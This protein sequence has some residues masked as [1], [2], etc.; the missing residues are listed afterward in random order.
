MSF[1]IISAIGSIGSAMATIMAVLVS[2][3]VWKSQR[4]LSQR[5]LLIPLWSHMSSINEISP[6]NPVGP[7][8][9]K[10]VNTLEL[11]ALCCEGGM[12]DKAVI[13]R[14]FQSVYL[15]LYQ[16]VEACS[17]VPGCQKSGREMLT[18]NRAAMALYTEL[19]NDHVK[20]GSL[21]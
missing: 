13:K 9:I 14:T 20:Q 1:Q 15:K 7:D 12:I 16:Q 8:V 18:E 3:L 11:V 4:S 21:I 5:Q 6:R 17:D 10:A 19:L 2:W